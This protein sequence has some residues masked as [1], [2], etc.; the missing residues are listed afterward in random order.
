MLKKPSAKKTGGP[1]RRATK[2]F[3]KGSSKKGKDP[4]ISDEEKVG[5]K[6]DEY[7]VSDA[8][9]EPV[10]QHHHHGNGKQ[11]AMISPDGRLV[12]N[13]AELQA[14]YATDVLE[15]WFAGCHGGK[16]NPSDTSCSD[17]SFLQ[18]WAG[19]TSRTLRR[20]LSQPSLSDGWSAKS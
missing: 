9:P 7:R 16:F 15:V 17:L 11:Q 2:L 12:G 20:T 3:R 18:T 19:A 4:R 13:P 5:L 14:G 6:D 8:G 1:L 10:E